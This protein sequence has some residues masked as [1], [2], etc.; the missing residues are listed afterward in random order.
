MRVVIASLF[1]FLAACSDLQVSR[2]PSA[3]VKPAPDRIIR[4]HSYIFG[5]I[6]QEKIYERDVCPGGR[7][8]TMQLRM[9]PGEV[10]LALVTLGIYFPQNVEISCHEN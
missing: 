10:G 8:E 7:I 1:I 4:I 5:A 9:S 2:G 3:T 6:S